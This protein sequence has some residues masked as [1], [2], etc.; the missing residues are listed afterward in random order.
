MSYSSQ[1]PSQLSVTTL[2]FVRRERSLSGGQRFFLAGGRVSCRRPFP[3]AA[4]LLACWS[5]DLMAAAAFCRCCVAIDC[6]SILSRSK[7]SL[8]RSPVP[9][10]FGGRP[11]RWNAGV[12][13]LSRLLA[14]SLCW[15]TT[16][17][18]I[19]EET[20]PHRIFRNVRKLVV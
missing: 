9:G 20:R 1:S 13:L 8:T 11:K 6:P 12:K 10:L 2:S 5:R 14:P 4:H 17:I 18:E 16:Q 3:P 15:V 7:N 19:N